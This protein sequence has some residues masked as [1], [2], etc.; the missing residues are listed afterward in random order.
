MLNKSPIVIKMSTMSP[1]LLKWLAGIC[2]PIYE[3]NI[4]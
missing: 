4:V 1:N 2:H 3:N